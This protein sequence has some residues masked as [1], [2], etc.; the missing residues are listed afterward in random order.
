M[1]TVVLDGY[2][3]N[4]GDLS[5]EPLKNLGDCKIY[6]RTSND[7][8]IQ[9]SRNADIILTNKVPM[10]E[11]TLKQ[12]SNLK[13]IC[14]TATGYNIVDVK[15][16][17]KLNIDVANIPTYC[18]HSVTQ[19]VFAHLFNLSLHMYEHTQS[20][21][22]GKWCSSRDFCYWL[23]PMLELS[24]LTIGLIGL[25]NIGRAVAKIANSFDMKVLA[26]KPSYSKDI[27]KYIEMVKNTNQIFKL[28]DIISLHCPLNAN[29]ETLVNRKTLG[30]MKSTSFIINTSR[31][32]LI[33]EPALAEALNAGKVSGAGL[34]VL[35]TE[36]PTKNNPLISA[37]NCYITPHIAWATVAAR[38]RLLNIIINNI[39][40]YSNG[41][42]INI[43]NR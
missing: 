21:R 1:K 17:R 41:H 3:L 15:A 13:Y 20:V 33:D 16:A 32:G 23:S 22:K 12:L 9:R 28:S 26:Y 37:K 8:I 19:M 18:A 25:G 4:P 11:A 36:P 29:T 24:G 35:S 5:W 30:L 10:T 6:D 7:T 38:K 27:P 31:G 39:K 40:S 34:D 2:A 42:P 43:V 14:V